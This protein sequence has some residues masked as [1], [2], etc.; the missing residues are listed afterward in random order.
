MLCHSGT[1][2][3][4]IVLGSWT[5]LS[6]GHSQKLD[7]PFLT[8][9]TKVLLISVELHFVHTPL[10]P[11]HSSLC[12]SRVFRKSIKYFGFFSFKAFLFIISVKAICRQA[13]YWW[14]HTPTHH[15][16]YSL[17]PVL[18]CLSTPAF[19]FL[20]R[21]KALFVLFVQHLAQLIPLPREELLGVVIVKEK[22]KLSH[23][24]Q[25]E[26]GNTIIKKFL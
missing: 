14:A 10:V 18:I 17:F 25:T 9:V 1:S 3:K 2:G 7:L 22:K 5:F 19:Y 21:L 13:G 8:S 16:F 12:L 15:H 20:C 23:I 11:Y 4:K 6:E 26:V 24:L